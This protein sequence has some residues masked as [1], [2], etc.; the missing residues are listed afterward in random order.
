MT[1]SLKWKDFLLLCLWHLLYSISSPT[2]NQA[3]VL[4][5]L[6]DPEAAGLCFFDKLSPPLDLWSFLP[7]SLLLKQAEEDGFNTLL[8]PPQS[9]PPAQA[10]SPIQ[11]FPHMAGIWFHHPL[12]TPA[13]SGLAEKNDQPP[14]LQS[15]LCPLLELHMRIMQGHILWHSS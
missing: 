9:S 15:G 13:L 14:S 1:L 2:P 5:C 8:A 11:A 7:T 6:S 12:T 4:L 3:R 10:I